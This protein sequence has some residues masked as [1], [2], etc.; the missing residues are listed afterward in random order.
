MLHVLGLGFLGSVLPWAENF[1]AEHFLCG[2]FQTNL[3]NSRGDLLVITLDLLTF[4]VNN[5]NGLFHHLIAFI[6][7]FSTEVLV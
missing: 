1:K 3:L 4:F 5:L 6:F 2:G 7:P